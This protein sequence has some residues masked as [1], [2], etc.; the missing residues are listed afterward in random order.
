[1]S[2]YGL[3]YISTFCISKICALKFVA[4]IIFKILKIKFAFSLEF[5]SLCK[6]SDSLI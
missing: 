1:M 4:I 3:T 5:D 2:S 6:K